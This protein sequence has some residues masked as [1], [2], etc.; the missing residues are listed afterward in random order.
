MT[1]YQNLIAGAFAPPVNGQ[2]IPYF[3]SV[4]ESQVGETADSDFMDA[5]RALQAANQANVLFAKIERRERLAE[6]SHF[7]SKIESRIADFTVALSLEQGASLALA[8]RSCAH[9]LMLAQKHLAAELDGSYAQAAHSLESNAESELVRRSVLAPLGVVAIITPRMD[10]FE[11]ILAKLLPALIAGN[12]VIIK[13]SSL[14]PR[15]TLCLAECIRDLCLKVDSSAGIDAIPKTYNP[16]G[17]PEASIGKSQWTAAWVQVLQGK[18]EKVGNALVIHPGIHTLSFTGQTSTAILIQKAASESFKRFHFSLSSRNPVLVFQETQ[19]DLVI[20]KLMDLCIRETGAKRG[21]RIFFHESVYKDYLAAFNRALE[22]IKL[23]SP[24]ESGTDLG[25]VPT[26]EIRAKL[27]TI[28]SGAKS[29]RAKLLNTA[30]AE[31]P[32]QGY[33]VQP[34]ALFD[35]TYCSTIQQEEITGPIVTITSFKYLHDVIKHAGT[36]PYGRIGYVFCD[37][38]EKAQRV[39]EKLDVETV[40][41]NPDPEKGQNLDDQSVASGGLRQSGWGAS[42]FREMIRFFSRETAVFGS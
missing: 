42:G 10:A 9:V 35:L 22:K 39:G 15:T 21:S 28:V 6:I 5:V 3:D 16:E 20:P 31:L 17:A 2:Y 26:A 32:N 34:E 7:L 4:S 1:R 33:F 27:K 14:A 8:K 29:E 23:G 30:L 36:S 41:L 11:T 25:P 24:I 37:D 12:M 40:L 18:G 13:G 38:S 19:V